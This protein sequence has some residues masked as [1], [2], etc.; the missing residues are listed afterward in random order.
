[1]KWLCWKFGVCLLV[2]PSFYM[3]HLCNVHD[4]NGTDYFKWSLS[5]GTWKCALSEIKHT[6]FHCSLG[7]CDLLAQCY[8]CIA[9]FISRV[10][11]SA[12]CRTKEKL[13]CFHSSVGQTVFE[14]E[15]AINFS[16]FMQQEIACLHPNCPFICTRGSSFILCPFCI[17][18]F[19]ATTFTYCDA[20]KPVAYQHIL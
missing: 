13:H 14:F 9:Q 18:K 17:M 10:V 5:R 1:M 15:A 7:A 20:N 6:V 4:W 3:Y 19:L 11:W 16:C 8:E 2:A 12:F